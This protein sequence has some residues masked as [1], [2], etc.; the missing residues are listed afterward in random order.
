MIVGLMLLDAIYQ[1][2]LFSLVNIS[3]IMCLVVFFFFL[4][5]SLI[6]SNETT[7]VR[8]SLECWSGKAHL[9]W[10]GR[11]KST[12][13]SL[14]GLWMLPQAEHVSGHHI[15]SHGKWCPTTTGIQ[16]KHWETSKV[17][18]WELSSRAQQQKTVTTK[19]VRSRIGEQKTESKTDTKKRQKWN[20]LITQGT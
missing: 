1:T 5:L 15:L 7:L 4:Y 8:K 9:I 12:S 13:L 11:Q 20:K 6:M 16:R 3:E 14:A 10:A 19:P 2:K 18:G 17:F